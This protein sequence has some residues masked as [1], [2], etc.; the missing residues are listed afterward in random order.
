MNNLG[1]PISESMVDVDGSLPNMSYYVINSLVPA[2]TVTVRIQGRTNGNWLKVDQLCL[3]G[4][5]PCADFTALAQTD[6]NLVK[7]RTISNEISCSGAVDRVFMQTV[8]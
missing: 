6:L 7:T 2:G 5:S 3:T 1:N 8:C 4:T